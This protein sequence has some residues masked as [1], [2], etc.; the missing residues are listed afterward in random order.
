MNSVG[1]NDQITGEHGFIIEC[2]D[3]CLGILQSS[4]NLKYD[5]ESQPLRTTD[6]TRDD[7]LM[8]TR[9]PLNSCAAVA[10]R[11]LCRSTR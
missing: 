2:D 7:N 8:L 4:I 5:N 1:T 9:L 6:C 3:S 10:R 11:V